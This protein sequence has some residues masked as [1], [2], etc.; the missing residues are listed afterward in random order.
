MK[1]I[2]RVLLVAN[3]KKENISSI[4]EEIL[5]I[6]RVR[7]IETE[8]V[9]PTFFQLNNKTTLTDVEE[10]FKFRDYDMVIAVGGDG[11]FLF[12]A[13]FFYEFGL[14][15]LG[16]NAGRMGFLMEISAGQF[17]SAIDKL[18]KN[19]FLIK[20][21]A[22]L[23]A[24]VLRD[25]KIV[26]QSPFLNDVVISKGILSR[27]V[28][29]LVY[30][31]EEPLAQYRADGLIVS[32]PTGSTAYNLSAGGPILLQDVNGMIIT[33]ICPHTLGVRPIVAGIEKELKICFL[34]GGSDTNLTIDG[35]E[36]F[37]LNVNDVITVKKEKK[38]VKIYD[39]GEKQFF[40]V[41]REKLGWHI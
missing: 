23:K 34:S 39:Y 3:I 6:L 10:P 29:I 8:M 21:R 40:K 16:I 15:I 22:I 7:N 26:F 30:I 18:A 35:Q 28:E 24:T 4:V 31:N 2:S 41:L 36:N 11:T 32:T 13:R 9:S 17:S 33:P 20:E 5:S 37:L 1:E 19:N 38:S 14:P 12:T 25:G 27:M